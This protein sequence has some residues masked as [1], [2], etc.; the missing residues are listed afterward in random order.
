MQIKFILCQENCVSSTPTRLL[1]EKIDFHFKRK[2]MDIV[3]EFGFL[4][5]CLQP[6]SI[7]YIYLILIKY[8]Y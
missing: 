7:C 3:V 8:Y 4:N 2:D 1:N 5:G 6:T